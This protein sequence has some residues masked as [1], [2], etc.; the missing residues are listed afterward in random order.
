LLINLHQLDEVLGG[1]FDVP[2]NAFYDMLVNSILPNT[3]G[4]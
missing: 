3:L 1:M 4:G 2:L